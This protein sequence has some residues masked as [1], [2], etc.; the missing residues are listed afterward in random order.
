MSFA[1]NVTTATTQTFPWSQVFTG[2]LTVATSVFLAWMLDKRKENLS[3]K[4]KH[5]EDLQRQLG[6]VSLVVND[7]VLQLWPCWS[8][9]TARCPI[10]GPSASPNT[11][12][13]ET[14]NIGTHQVIHSVGK[15]TIAEIPNE[16]LYEDFKHHFPELSNYLQDWQDKVRT[17]GPKVLRSY[18][19][20]CDALYDDTA[21]LN[22]A[23]R[24]KSGIGYA[25]EGG[26]P[27]D[28]ATL[29][30]LLGIEEKYWPN[31]KSSVEPMIGEV[32]KI[33]KKYEG[34]TEVST[35]TRSLNEFEQL[36]SK[37][38][39]AIEEVGVTTHLKGRCKFL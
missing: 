17:D 10:R 26:H 32:L 37:C 24:E 5:L 1:L 27:Y 13:L 28:A 31:L 6:I 36:K 30:I 14:Y 19:D 12:P 3:R 7:P 23:I 18:Y 35:I 15:E 39:K 22:I 9:D 4:Q 29:N 2:V 11:Y 21:N 8:P 25:I 33:V 16:T 34:R 38:D 20:I